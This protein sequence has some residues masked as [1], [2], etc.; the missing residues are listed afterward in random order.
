MY[1]LLLVLILSLACGTVISQRV[2][3]SRRYF[4]SSLESS[5]VCVCNSTYC[6]TIES[7]DNTLDKTVYYQEYITSRINYRLD[8]FVSTFS[9]QGWKSLGLLNLKINRAKS[10]QKTTGF[11]GSMTDSTV[12]Y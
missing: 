8:K 2:A 10:Y 1:A 3:C 9:T 7:V 11:G 6:D 5:F 12:F 4:T